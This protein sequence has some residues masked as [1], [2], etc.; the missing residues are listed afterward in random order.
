MK[1]IERDHDS[2]MMQWR[3]WGI[4]IMGRDKNLCVDDYSM[5]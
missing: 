2:R 5:I 4:C 1:N 3:I